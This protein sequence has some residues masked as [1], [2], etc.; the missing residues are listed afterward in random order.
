[1]SKS[2]ITPAQRKLIDAHP[3][4]GPDVIIHNRFTGAPVKVSAQVKVLYLAAME[5]YSRIQQGEHKLV[6]KFDALRYAVLALD[7]NAYSSLLD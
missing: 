5:L 7:P 4:S 6:R 2:K 1:M 3:A